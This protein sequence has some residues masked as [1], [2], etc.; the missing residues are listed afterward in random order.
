MAREDPLW[1]RFVSGGLGDSTAALFSHPADVLKVR[2]QL[3]G[4]CDPSKRSLSPKDFSLAARRLVMVEG[5]RSGLYAGLSASIMRQ[6]VFSG[7]RHGLFG[8]FERN[9]RWRMRGDTASTSSTSSPGVRLGCAIAAGTIAAV[10]ANPTDVVLVR[11]QADGGL[12]E[13]RR[14]G[15]RHVLDGIAR[16]AREE[17]VPALWRGCSPTVIR[18][19]LVTA[20]QITAYEEAK[21][22]L[23]RS[24]MPDGSRTQL[25]S[26]MTSAT[27][28]CV[29]TSPVDVVKTRYMSAQAAAATSQAAEGVSYKGPADVVMSTLRTEGPMAFYK[30]ISATFLRLWPHTVILWLAQE[31]IAG[32]LRRVSA[33][34]KTA[35]AA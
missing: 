20:S 18:A 21:A 32:Q 7:L 30:G 2:L 24:G 13:S 28:A 31:R 1:H 33:A 15:Y 27:L 4:E 3:T 10:I 26:A 8:V 16:I 9:A 25:I 17:G 29:V 11:M 34:A 6:C 14:R 12:P 23:L 35:E 5:V 19:V 22:G